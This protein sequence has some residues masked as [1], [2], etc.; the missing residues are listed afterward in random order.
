MKARSWN[1][2]PV[3]ALAAFGLS[4]ALVGYADQVQAASTAAAVPTAVMAPAQVGLPPVPTEALRMSQAGMS[5]DVII[6]YIQKSANPYILDAEQII[7]LH[8]VGISSTV[9]DALV[10]HGGTAS[11]NPVAESPGDTADTGNIS[12]TGTPPVSGPAASFYNSLAPYGTWL[13]VP[14]Y[15]WCWQPTVVL[16]DPAWQPYCNNGSWL[17][18]DQGWYWNSYYSWGWA[19]FHYGRWCQSPGHGWVWCPDSTWGP[20]WVCWRDYP[21]YCGWAPLPPGACFVAGTGWTFNGLAVGFN[22]GFGLGARCFTFCDFDDFCGRH[23]FAHF[24]HGHD[25]DR[26]FRDSRVNNDFALDAQHRFFNR[27][28]DPSRIEA[29]THTRIGQVSV[30]ELPHGAGRDGDFDRPDRLTR[31]GHD[32]VIFRPGQDLSTMQNQFRSDR[33]MSSAN[34]RGNDAA[35]HGFNAGRGVGNPTGFQPGRPN[36]FQHSTPNVSMNPSYGNAPNRSWNG[37][38]PSQVRSS[39]PASS[40]RRND[41]DSRNFA[42]TPAWHPAPTWQP[43]PAWHPAP[44]QSWNGGSQNS[45]GTRSWNG[46]SQNWGSGSQNWNG[47]TPSWGGGMSSGHSYHR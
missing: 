14:G 36:T 8:D 34:H 2:T 20:A 6:A 45:G 38:G 10:T 29:A 18:T 40:Y 37:A 28:I 4:V 25:A 24:R 3:A 5:D 23:S 12:T 15:G 46:G 13:N 42:P 32:Q 39:R 27:G 1:E 17:W 43:A 7:Y 16:V 30:R 9:L 22:F 21:G 11:G 31:S 41:S 33:Q 44:S 19:P 35:T 26:F 47:G